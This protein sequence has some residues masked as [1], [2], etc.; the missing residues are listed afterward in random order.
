M[1]KKIGELTD[2]ERIRTLDYLYTAAGSISGRDGMKRFLKNLLTTSERVMLGRR[3]W[4]ARLLLS[5]VSEAEVAR[6][7]QASPSTIYRVKS[8]LE[9]QM[10]GYEDAIRGLEKEMDRRAIRREIK[11]DPFSYPALKKKY[12]LHFLL[13]PSPKPKAKYRD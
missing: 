7:L 9:D 13:F 2:K 4:I 5:G 8:W 12:P 3:I 1:K 11:D 6:E 10:P